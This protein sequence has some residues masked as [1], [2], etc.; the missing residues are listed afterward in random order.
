MLTTPHPT[1]VHGATGDIGRVPAVGFQLEKLGYQAERFNASLR[2]EL[3][4]APISNPGTT[5]RPLL[6]SEA[7][8][9]MSP[10][11]PRR[12]SRTSLRIPAVRGVAKDVP[13]VTW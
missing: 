4:M 5:S 2:S 10:D 11:L 9:P 6:S 8:E 12:S 7:P 3:V 13:E 1:W